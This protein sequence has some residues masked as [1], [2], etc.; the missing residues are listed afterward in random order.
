METITV[1]EAIK[2]TIKVLEDIM[3]PG[4]YLD[5]IGEP[6]KGSIRNLNMCINAIEQAEQ[7]KAQPAEQ[8]APAEEVIDMDAIEENAEEQTDAE[9]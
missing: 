9:T 4:K 8:E 1:K 6:I 2:V 5:Q 3:V 7:E